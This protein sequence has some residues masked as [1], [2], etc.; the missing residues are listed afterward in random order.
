MATYDD[1]D[2]VYFTLQALRLFH[3]L[4]ST[5]LLVVD[6]HGCAHTREFVRGAGVT[7]VL[8]NDVVGTAPARDRVFSAA[9]GKAVLC[10]DSH[11]LFD[12]GV[13]ARLRRFYRDTPACDDL[14]QGPMVYDDGLLV[15]T[16]LQPVWREQMWG[17]WATDPRGRDPDGDAFDIPMQGLGAFTC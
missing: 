17:I 9:R 7:Y 6:N 4:D 15:S 5:E 11:V 16:H 2:G 13:V 10:C 1:F 14:L 8:A 3:D 12:K